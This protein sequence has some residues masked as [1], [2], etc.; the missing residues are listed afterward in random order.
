MSKT[1]YK[2]FGSYEPVSK[3]YELYN[4]PYIETYQ[5]AHIATDVTCPLSKQGRLCWENSIGSGENVL[6]PYQYKNLKDSDYQNKF[7]RNSEKSSMSWFGSRPINYVISVS[8]YLTM[9]IFPILLLL[10]SVSLVN[11]RLIILS[12]ILCS[13]GWCWSNSW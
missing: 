2:K 7:D 3:I 4:L 9:N 13:F 11:C 6:L 12:S 1:T 8:I 5:Q 10:H